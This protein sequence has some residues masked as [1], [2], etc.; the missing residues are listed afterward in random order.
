MKALLILPAFKHLVILEFGKR[1]SSL[2]CCGLYLGTCRLPRQWWLEG[3]VCMYVCLNRTWQFSSTSELATS[4][5]QCFTS[6]REMK[7][8]CSWWGCSAP[9]CCVTFISG[10]VL[11]PLLGSFWSPQ[12]AA[13]S[14][15]LLHN[16]DKQ[17]GWEC[18]AS[19]ISESTGSPWQWLCAGDRK[20]R[21]GLAHV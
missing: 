20:P 18:S 17:W 11:L 16:T 8:T 12:R 3:F 13:S 19:R 10:A 1:A 7:L 6:C 21:F 14:T 5:T 15:F 4:S 2:T 9:G